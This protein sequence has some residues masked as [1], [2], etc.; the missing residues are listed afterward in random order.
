MNESRY[1]NR[2][3]KQD[4]YS[5]PA[6]RSATI[7]FN[8][9]LFPGH[10]ATELPWPAHLSTGPV[11]VPITAEPDSDSE[12]GFL[13]GAILEI[14]CFQKV[15]GKWIFW[16]FAWATCWVILERAAFRWKAATHVCS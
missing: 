5:A 2:D 14:K 15:H 12:E 8:A 9:V 13:V 4:F 10:E 3:L 7:S 1:D 16:S 11:E 6:Y